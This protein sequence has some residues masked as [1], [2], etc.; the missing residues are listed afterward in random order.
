MVG[1]VKPLAELERLAVDPRRAI[2][3]GGGRQV[4]EPFVGDRQ[5]ALVAG[6][7]GVGPGQPLAD[8]QG[9]PVEPGGLAGVPG[10]PGQVTEPVVRDRQVALEPGVGGVGLGFALVDGQ[11]RRSPGRSLWVQW[12][13]GVQTRLQLAALCHSSISRRTACSDNIARAVWLLTALMLMPI[14]EAICASD[15]S[16]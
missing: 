8:G 11:G 7:G 12:P 1:S 9:L 10:I 15:R 14:V 3:I 16:A 5:V 13:L 2:R 4:A 6:V